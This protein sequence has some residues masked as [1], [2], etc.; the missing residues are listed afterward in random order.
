MEYKDEKL[1][2]LRRTLLLSLVIDRSIE[3]QILT[4]KPQKLHVAHVQSSA[5][6]L[7]ELDKLPPYSATILDA[8]LPES[9]FYS[10]VATFKEACLNIG[11]FGPGPAQTGLDRT[12]YTH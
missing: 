2:F 10:R 4:L 6:Q 12:V 5:R 3:S 11:N 1:R 9:G 7:N 8:I